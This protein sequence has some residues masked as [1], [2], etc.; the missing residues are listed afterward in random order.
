MEMTGSSEILSSEKRQ[1]EGRQKIK[2]KLREG[3][4]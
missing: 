4:I 1:K 3:E 2:R